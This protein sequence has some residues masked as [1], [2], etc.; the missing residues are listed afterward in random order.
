MDVGAWLRDLGFEAYLE[1]F[2][3]NGVDAGL[4]P[5]LTNE[6]LKDLGVARLA[7]RKR[8]LNAIARLSEAN[9]DSW[10]MP[11][12]PA[13]PVDERRQV[14][15]LFADL[16]GFTRLSSE[17]D[18]EET[19]ALLNRYFETVD[20]IVESYGGTVDKHI[21]DNVMAVFGAPVA[22]TDDPQRA[23]R[24]A[25]E[26]HHA[27][28]GLSDEMGRDLAAHIGIASGQVVASGT[29]SDAHREYTVTGDTVNLASRLDDLAG[30]GET[31]I[32]EAVRRAVSQMAVC[33]SRGQVSVKGIDRKIEVWAVQELAAVP[34]SGHQTAIVGRRPE[35]RQFTS[36]LDEAMEHDTGHSLLVRGEP[37][38]GKTRLIEEFIRIADDKGFA[39]HKALILD[40]GVGK[41]QDAIRALVRSVLAVSGISSENEREAAVRQARETNL[42]SK[43]RSVFLY[44]LLDISQPTE[45]SSI[46]DA[47]DGETRK[48]GARETV[49]ELIKCRAKFEPQLLVV[50]DLHWADDAILHHLT[51]IARIGAE[52]PVVLVMTTR[53][54]GLTLEKE[55][56]ASLRGCPLTTIELQPLRQ[57]EALKLAADLAD[58]EVSALEAIVAR[59]EGN[60][61]YLEQ[62]IQNASD[63]S[64]HDLPDT[65]QGVVLARIDRLSRTDRDAIRA[66]SVLGQRFSLPAL[67]SLLG[68]AGYDCAALL[69]HRLIRPEGPDY[70]FAHALV[71]DG[72]YASLLRASRRSLHALAATFYAERDKVL[73][74]EHLDR[75]S[76]T[77]APK[78]YLAAAQEQ[79]DRTRYED[80]LRLVR[81][82]LEITPAEESFELRLLEG[83]LL[84]YLGSI[85][86][87]I[88]AYKD[89]LEYALNGLERCRARIG[90]AEGLRLSEQ[91]IELLNTLDSAE[92]DAGTLDLFA[93]RARIHQLRGGVHFTRGEIDAC[94]RANE[95]SLKAARAGM[96][97]RLEA[98][99][100]GGLGDAEFARGRMISAH[101]YFDQ[102]IE[103]S[104]AHNFTGIMAAN[105]SMRGQTFLYQHQLEAAIEDCRAAAELA[106]KIRQPRA[107]MI[108]AIVA[109]YVLDLHDPQEGRIWAERSL[110]IARRLG[111]KLFEEINLEFLA[112]F[113][114]QEGD[115]IEA[116]KHMHKAIAILRESESGMRFEGPRSLGTLALFTSDLE[117]R[118]AALEEAEE[119]LRL[120]TT[121]HNYLAGYA[122]FS[123]SLR[124][125]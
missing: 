79:A 90:L 16:S 103:L 125:L 42:V 69:D 119:L 29:G 98:Q 92:E 41:G 94:L 111:S 122:P 106:G 46:F 67:H 82:A 84:R 62:L 36:L 40:F 91:H 27:M 101:R 43:G 22:H 21:G 8:L 7:D 26:I 45:L 1:A 112:R 54:E 60:P 3:E 97:P 68:E 57:S 37:G 9:R 95:N 32:S 107:E 63:A 18:A 118:R 99:A 105:L 74:A 38:I 59:A 100:Y 48:E 17:L 89:A 50:E 24:A 113:A 72:V 81:R 53:V 86:K 31:L 83:E 58:S 109:T 25:A 65:L 5:G 102:C 23:V 96:S 12:K 49:S 110:D 39:T 115:L 66:A 51:D 124:S 2:A 52:A 70:L 120:G 56:L 76:S 11:A 114:A 75:A 14:T 15:V 4:L 71:R 80:A 117:R 104:R 123:A 10:T 85:A 30:A 13:T 88:R 6:D 121:G 47:M 78:A 55:W 20:G 87:S 44:D 34:S 73:H 116:Q 93:E 61:L 35:L 108:A 77:D 64:S 19:H 33:A 28:I